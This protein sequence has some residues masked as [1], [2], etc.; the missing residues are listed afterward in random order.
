MGFSIRYSAAIATV[1]LFISPAHAEAQRSSLETAKELLKAGKPD[2][3]LA[4]VNPIIAQALLTDAKDPTAM[5]PGVATAV[6]QSY[7]KGSFSIS[8]ENDWCDAMLVKGYALNDL[9]RPAEAAQVLESLVR[10]DPV[11]PNYLIEH[12]YTVRVNG[13]LERSLA[14]YITAEKIAWKLKDP[15]RAAHWQAVAL[16]GEGFACSEL[17]RWDDAAKAYNRSLKYEPDSENA[18]NELRYIEQNR[19]H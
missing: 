7:M 6:L 16:R 10:H 13:E 3:S 18:R 2:Q 14:L 15:V 5:C 19:T 4:L 12:A 11:N 8:V 17:K 9:K 1:A